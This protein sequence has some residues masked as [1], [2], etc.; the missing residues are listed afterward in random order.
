MKNDKWEGIT[1]EKPLAQKQRTQ[2]GWDGQYL[3]KFPKC[4]LTP[5][6]DCQQAGLGGEQGP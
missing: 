3:L 4:E 2:A 5:E 6:S 1:L